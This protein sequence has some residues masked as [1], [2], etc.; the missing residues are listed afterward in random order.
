M[1]VFQEG[2]FFSLTAP[3]LSS[4]SALQ[5]IRFC[6]ASAAYQCSRVKWR[7]ACMTNVISHF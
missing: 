1:G 6:P 3:G 7:I 2:P 4:L 5:M